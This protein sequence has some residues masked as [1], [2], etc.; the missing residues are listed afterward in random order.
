MRKWVRIAS[1]FE[2]DSRIVFIAYTKS[3]FYL[4]QVG[5]NTPDF[6]SNLIIRS[7]LWDDTCN[8]AVILTDVLNL[9][10]YTAL[11]A[12]DMEKAEKSGLVFEKCRCD[13]CATCGKC[14][15][16]SIKTIITYIH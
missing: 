8:K 6:P 10:V 9:P 2:D 5:Y 14:W 12:A 11:S 7:S 4:P 15:D 16:K 3:I 13:D 1:A